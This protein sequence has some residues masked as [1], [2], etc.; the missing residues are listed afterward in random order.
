MDS[1]LVPGL[2]F[3]VVKGRDP[4]GAAPDSRGEAPRGP[5]PGG[6]EVAFSEARGSDRMPPRRTRSWVESRRSPTLCS[7]RRRAGSSTPR[8]TSA[9]S[10]P[11]TRCKRPNSNSRPIAEASATSSRHGRRADRAGD[12]RCR[13]R[14]PAGESIETGGERSISGRAHGL[15]RHEGI[16]SARAPHVL[17][18]E[19]DRRRFGSG[20]R[21]GADH[22][23]EKRFYASGVG[24]VTVWDT[25][26]LASSFICGRSSPAPA[27]RA[28]IAA[29]TCTEGARPRR[30]GDVYWSN[31]Q[32]G[33]VYVYRAAIW[34]A[35]TRCR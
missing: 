35:R 32:D 24:K 21:E 13:G 34:R 31:I 15:D 14:A 28:S 18:E 20:A 16:A 12:G 33:K 9:S 7:T 8:A 30:D 1:R 6:D 11:D 22:P 2:A 17:A 26:D 4:G 25:I 3:E 19:R 23:N 5:P 10:R 29:S 27:A